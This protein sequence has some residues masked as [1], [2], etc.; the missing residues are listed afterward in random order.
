[1]QTSAPLPPV[2]GRTASTGSVLLAST[3][4]VAPNARGQLELARVE[5]D[6]DD[7]GRPG[8]LRPGDGGTPDAA[9]AED[10]DRVAEPDLAGE[11]GGAE[12]RHHAAARAARPPRAG[13]PG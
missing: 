10:G 9:A 1:M 8:E 7:G 6:A 4:C 11:H 2:I 3:V 12:A 5:V 13:P